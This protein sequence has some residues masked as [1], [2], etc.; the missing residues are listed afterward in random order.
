MQEQYY[1][2][3]TVKMMQTVLDEAWISLQPEQ[4]ARSN[5]TFLATIILDIAAAG[6]RDP[7][8]VR[9]KAVTRFVAVGL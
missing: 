8:L 3:H 7:I 4:R 6:E 1:D 5:K 2:P 9:T